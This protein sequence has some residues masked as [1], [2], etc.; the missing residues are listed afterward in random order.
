MEWWSRRD[1]LYMTVGAPFAWSFA[2]GENSH[3][4][5]GQDRD[6]MKVIRSQAFTAPRW[7]PMNIVVE[8]KFEVPTTMESVLYGPLEGDP[9]EVATKERRASWWY[10]RIRW[11]GDDLLELLEADRRYE[12]WLVGIPGEVTEP[13]IQITN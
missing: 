13:Y 4:D 8:A 5:T 9:E 2:A 1:M 11:L 7:Q 10:Q 3:R 12:V 6:R